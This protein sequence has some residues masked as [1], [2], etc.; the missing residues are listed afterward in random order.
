MRVKVFAKMSQAEVKLVDEVAEAMGLDRQ[1]YT[2]LAILRFTD[3]VVDAIYKG[4]RKDERTDT[5]T[6]EVKELT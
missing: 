3:S 1:R 4:V 2:R 5:P 6:G